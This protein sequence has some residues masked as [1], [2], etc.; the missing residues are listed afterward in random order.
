MVFRSV[1]EVVVLKKLSDTR[2]RN[3]S[4]SMVPPSKCSHPPYSTLKLISANYKSC[5]SFWRPFVWCN[6]AKSNGWEAFTFFGG[7]YVSRCFEIIALNHGRIYSLQWVMIGQGVKFWNQPYLEYNVC[8]AVDC[9]CHW[10]FMEIKMQH[11]WRPCVNLFVFNT[12]NARKLKNIE[13]MENG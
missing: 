2:V 4:S 10:R 6:D 8:P 7:E 1:F 11:E 13:W 9:I 5:S 3:G 12:E